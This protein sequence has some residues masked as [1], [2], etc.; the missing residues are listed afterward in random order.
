MSRAYAPKSKGL[1]QSSIRLLAR[2]ASAVPRVPF[3]ASRWQGDREASVWNEWSLVLFVEYCLTTPSAKT[4][5]L[6][7]AGSIETY[8][9]LLKGYLIFTYDFEIR[10]GAPRLSRLI[11]LIKSEDP[12]GGVRR[13]RRGFRRRH[14]RR[15]WA[16]S[17]AVA[18]P[19][20]AAA[21]RIAALSTAWHV[22]ARG[23]ELC[24]DKFDARRHATRAD[25]E[26]HVTSDGRRYAIVWLR[27]LKK[28][29]SALQPKV[30]QYI[31][32]ADG[33]GSDVHMLLRRMVDLDPVA[34]EH[35]A[36]TPMF[37]IR[38]GHGAMRAMKV[39]QLREFTKDCAAAIGYGVAPH[40]ESKR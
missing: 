3:K 8:V 7:Q 23:G 9:S 15:V 34:S 36:A 37:R 13:K 2:F 14:L 39:K 31:A 21:T 12:L 32:E 40:A 24:A 11:K 22:L 27:P 35:R 20:A 6:L 18:A 4:K 26:F 25:L 30:P 19:T 10:E 16:Q 33:G 29:S 5:R 17:A 1:L 28:R 38:D